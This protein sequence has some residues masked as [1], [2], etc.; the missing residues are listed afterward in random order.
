MTIDQFKKIFLDNGGILGGP[1][2]EKI[3]VNTKDKQI[4]AQLLKKKE[5]R[6]FMVDLLERKIYEGSLY[7]NTEGNFFGYLDFPPISYN[8]NELPKVR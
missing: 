8:K 4:F 2:I 7:R 3:L 6:H 1:I 5:V